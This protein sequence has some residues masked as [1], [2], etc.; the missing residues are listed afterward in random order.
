MKKFCFIFIVFSLLVFV[1]CGG[2]KSE[3][4]EGSSDSGDTAS[5]GDGDTEPAGDTEP[6][7]DTEPAGNTEPGGDTEP[8][9]DSG[10]TT[11]EQPDNGDSEPETDPCKESNPCAGLANSTEKCISENGHYQCGCNKG[12]MWNSAAKGCS[13][14]TIGR[15][16]SGQT[17]CVDSEG[18]YFENCPASETDDFFGQDGYFASRNG[19]VKK[20]LSVKTY[21][22]GEE[23]VVENV[24]KLEWLRS[25]STEK[26]TWEKAQTYCED[27]DYAGYKDWRVPSPQE[28]FM[29][30][31]FGE[32]WAVSS[33]LFLNYPTPYD[34]L[35]TSF[36][37]PYSSSTTYGFTV[38]PADGDNWFD[39]VMNEQYVIC[40][41]GETL[42]AAELAVSGKEG[43]KT[44][45]DSI[46]KL[47]WQKNYPKE[48]KNWKE[49]LAYCTKL[50]YA[51]FSDWRMPNVMEMASNLNYDGLDLAATGGAMEKIFWTST[52]MP[53]NPAYQYTAASDW[54]IISKDI[55]NNSA[56]VRCVRDAE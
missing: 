17:A 31:D 56:F 23:T 46:S 13:L 36:S 32:S 42:P 26:Y 29:I 44:E 9:G 24:S 8:S 27:L 34:Y 41:R 19:C 2:S 22:S 33:E 3:N 6:S 21:D 4:K 18:N 37:S 48:A 39:D 47:M 25:F 38:Y 1:S 55:K 35:W 45:T 54:A 51:G 53:D 16:C 15:I 52:Y 40:V 20:S 10:D 11:P 14:L 28:F 7:G 12:Y 5:D 50:E 49:A 43:E 30:S